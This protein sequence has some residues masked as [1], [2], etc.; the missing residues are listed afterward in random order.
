M[1][2]TKARKEEL[3]NQYQN[4]I[5]E[6]QAFIL[7]EYQGVTMKEMDTLRAKARD[8]G[9]EFHV[10]KNTLSKLAFEKAGIDIPDNILSDTTAMAIAFEDAPSLAKVISEFSRDSEFIKI[11]CGFIDKAMI[12][13][14]EVKSLAELPPLPV[15]RAMLMGTLLAPATKLTRTLAEPGRQVVSVMNAYATQDKVN[16]SA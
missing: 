13:E 14:A 16:A 9:A 7:T 5:N 10:I 11:K 2:I 15:V 3:I 12:S 1:A 6:S 8:I 4:W